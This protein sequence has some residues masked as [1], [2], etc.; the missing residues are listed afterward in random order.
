MVCNSITILEAC[1]YGFTTD[2][3]AY[4]GNGYCALRHKQTRKQWGWKESWCWGEKT[5]VC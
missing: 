1:L 4:K 3:I 2:K 5:Y